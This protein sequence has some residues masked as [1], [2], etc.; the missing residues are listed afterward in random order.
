MLDGDV[1]KG[2][3]CSANLRSAEKAKAGVVQ[4]LDISNNTQKVVTSNF[5]RDVD[6]ELATS[7][8]PS[9]LNRAPP[10]AIMV[11]LSRLPVFCVNEGRAKSM[12]FL[13]VE[14]NSEEDFKGLASSCAFIGLFSA[15]FSNGHITA[16]ARDE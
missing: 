16:R 3:A 12:L 7:C 15:G 4:V 6:S 1:C 10:Y 14:D 8:T 5:R 13:G 11:I 2:V 9:P